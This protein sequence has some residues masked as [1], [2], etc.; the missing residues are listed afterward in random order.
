MSHQEE[1]S[2]DCPACGDEIYRPLDWFKQGSFACPACGATLFYTQFATL[3]GELEAA[4]DARI[5]EEFA[6]P[7][8]G[9]G[10]GCC[11]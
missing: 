10:G 11:G 8:C 4:F 6:R 2:L 5:A 9:C 1:I 7:G 3:L